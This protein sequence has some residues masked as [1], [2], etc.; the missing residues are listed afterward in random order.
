MLNNNNNININEI[1]IENS[2]QIGIEILDNLEKQNELLQYSENKLEDAEEITKQSQRK[3]RGMTWWGSILNFFTFDF[4]PK[5][6]INKNE[7]V[8]KS[9]DLETGQT[10][11][12]IDQMLIIANNMNNILKNNNESIDKIETKINKLDNDFII[13]KTKINNIM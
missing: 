4:Y 1:L 3:V 5:K 8:I 11:N 2:V 13:L 12:N 9:I 7:K 10:E 6:E